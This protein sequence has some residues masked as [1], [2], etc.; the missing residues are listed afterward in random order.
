[1]WL[2][3][4]ICLQP[5]CFHNS[6]HLPRAKFPILCAF[7]PALAY[8]LQVSIT[9]VHTV[10]LSLHSVKGTFHVLK[11]FGGSPSQREDCERRSIAPA[12][13]VLCLACGSWQRWPWWDVCV[14]LCGYLYGRIPPIWSRTAVLSTKVQRVSR[15]EVP[16]QP[17]GDYLHLGR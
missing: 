3:V 10:P 9:H 11:G 2:I 5:H 17:N 15:L 1:M 4:S 7:R 8:T 6:S 13:I 14:C 12:A 16:L